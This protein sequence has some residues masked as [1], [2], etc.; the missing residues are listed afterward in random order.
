MYRITRV[1]GRG[2]RTTVVHPEARPPFRFENTGRPR[3]EKCAATESV[4]RPPLSRL[5][6]RSL[7]LRHTT[8]FWPL[9]RPLSLAFRSPSKSAPRAPLQPPSAR[10]RVRESC[11]S[12]FFHWS[13]RGPCGSRSRMPATFPLYRLSFSLSSPPPLS[14]SLWR[15]ARGPRRVTD[16]PPSENAYAH[17]TWFFSH[18]GPYSRF[19]S[20]L[21]FPHSLSLSL[22]S[23]LLPSSPSPCT[24]SRYVARSPRRLLPALS[25]LYL[26]RF[27]ASS[28][29]PPAILLSSKMPPIKTQKFRTEIWKSPRLILNCVILHRRILCIFIALTNKLIFAIKII[30]Q[31]IFPKI[32]KSLSQKVSF[33]VMVFFMTIS[34]IRKN[35]CAFSISTR[36]A[37]KDHAGSSS[38][39]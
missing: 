33:I 4:L 3:E 18:N 10:S 21:L 24:P 39:S 32:R 14:L 13:K 1:S 22:P 11:I 28:S 30:I 27:I 26:R 35:L 20:V 9:S 8:F 37:L 12:I 17:G 19:P 23:L 25:P 16:K 38:S 29:P 31:V 7:S 34:F 5:P 36:R 2:V 15:R 6:R